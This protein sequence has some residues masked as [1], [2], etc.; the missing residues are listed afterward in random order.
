VPAPPRELAAASTVGCGIEL[1]SNAARL[2][3]HLTASTS[4]GRSGIG[5]GRH[6]DHVLA[7]VVDQ[8]EG[9]PDG[10]S[11][12]P[13]EAEIDPRRQA[14]ECAVVLRG[15]ERVTK[16]TDAPARPRATAWLAP[17]RPRSRGSR[18]R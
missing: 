2:D 5:A 18:R 3:G 11:G 16:T 6:G 13:D 7:G 4:S 17:C 1:T 14:V 12:T 10:A 8:D 9:N 15:A